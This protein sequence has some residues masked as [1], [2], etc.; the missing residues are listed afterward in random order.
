MLFLARF[1]VVNIYFAV[2]FPLF[3]KAVQGS[4]Y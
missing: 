2:P 1:L 3:I 4:G